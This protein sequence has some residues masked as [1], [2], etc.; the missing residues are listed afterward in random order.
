MVAMGVWLGVVGLRDLLRAARDVTS[1]R[2]RAALVV[3][4][5]CLFVVAGGMLG[6]SASRGR[7]GLGLARAAGLLAWVL[8][9]SATLREPVP[10]TPTERRRD[11]AARLVAFAG[12]GLG[13]PGR[14]RRAAG[15]LGDR[16]PQPPC[17]PALR[18]R[19]PCS[20]APCSASSTPTCSCWPSAWCSR[21]SPPP[22]RRPPRAG[23]GGGA[24]RRRGAPAQGRTCAGAAGK[25]VRRRPRG[26]GCARGGGRRRRGQGAAAVPRAAGRVGSA[27]RPRRM[28]A[29]TGD[30]VATVGPDAGSPDADAA[31]RAPSTSSSAA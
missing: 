23:R 5:P 26:A 28:P 6:L 2:R 4:G 14:R 30:P 16:A 17:A 1:L 27:G 8:G 31:E 18:W 24:G 20:P 25:A 3:V 19:A 7:R 13:S 22:T 15:V 12:L 21:A 10:R 11:R 9:S 29:G